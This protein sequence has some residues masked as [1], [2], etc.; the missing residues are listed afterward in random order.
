MSSIVKIKLKGA[1]DALSKKDYAGAR[2]AASQILD[3]EPEN[4]NACV[5]SI[6]LH[7]ELLTGR[8]Q[9]RFLRTCPSGARRSREKRTSTVRCNQTGQYCLL[10][11]FLGL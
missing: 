5:N 6:Q 11:P 8:I 4:Y 10:T 2:D 1:R 9:Q 3:Y 7:S